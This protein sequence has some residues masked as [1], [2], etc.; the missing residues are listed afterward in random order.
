MVLED[1]TDKELSQG[2]IATATATGIVEHEYIQPRPPGPCSA[3]LILLLVAGFIFIR[4][5]D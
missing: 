5:S 2:K 4:K 3:A 1:G